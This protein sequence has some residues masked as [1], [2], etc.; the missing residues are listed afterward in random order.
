MP[1]ATFIDCPPFLHELYQGEL[2][3]IVPDLEIN[4]G[5]PSADEVKALL[6][7]SRFALLDHTTM[8]ASL[9]EAC[10]PLQAIVF[11]GLGAGSFIDLDAAKRLGITVRNYGGYGDRSVA[12]HA[13]ALMFAAGRRIAAMDRAVRAG[14][15]EPLDGIEFAGRTLGVV[16]TGGI[17]QAMIRLG[18]GIGMEVIAW[19]RSGVPDGLPCRPVDLDELLSSADVVSL[20]IALNDQTR[21]LID[22]RR[23]DLLRETAI[24]VN[25]A[26][27]AVL[28]ESALIA[29]LRAGRIAHAALDV[30]ED[31][32][33]PADHPLAI[34]D[35]TTLTPHAA[36]MTR[37]ASTRLL[38]MALDI[39]KQEIAD[40]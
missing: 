38:R 3:G 19:N 14:V 8:D 21:G 13:L 18:A 39:L 7:E 35:N 2:A 27:G 25:T 12:E 34:L 16:G 5:S 9:L 32:P 23:L 29:A 15:F 33:I 36:F 11:L 30:F 4:V 20:H 28:D 37:E 1:K 17:G 31:E 24:L 10:A 26:R 6:A 22:A 40:A